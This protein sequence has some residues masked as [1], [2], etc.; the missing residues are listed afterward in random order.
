M[1]IMKSIFYLYIAFICILLICIVQKEI[2]KFHLKIYHKKSIN[3][4]VYIFVVVM[5]SFNL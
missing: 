4:L 2:K 5:R 1:Y 3:L